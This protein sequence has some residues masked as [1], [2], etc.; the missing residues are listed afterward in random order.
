M[1]TDYETAAMRAMQEEW[2]PGTAV[3]QTNVPARDGAGGLEAVGSPVG[4]VPAMS[5][6]VLVL[7]GPNLNMLGIREPQTYGA[8]TLADVEAMCRAEGVLLG[9]DVECRQSNRAG[10]LCEW[11]Q[12]G[13][14][15]IQGIGINPARGHAIPALS[16]RPT[17]GVQVTF[18][19]AAIEPERVLRE[20]ARG[21]DCVAQQPQPRGLVA[22][23]S[24]GAL[25]VTATPDSC[26]PVTLT[27]SPMVRGSWVIADYYADL[28][29]LSPVTRLRIEVGST[30]CS[31]AV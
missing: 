31:S 14:G 2:L 15:K 5:T 17:M 29:D 11:I 28:P 1:L 16:P 25:R 18:R 13:Y 8:Q 7:N 30:A 3:I 23:G 22:A 9:L 21:G 26:V 19:R 24:L 4:A 12:E 27:A 6:R 20:I 10:E